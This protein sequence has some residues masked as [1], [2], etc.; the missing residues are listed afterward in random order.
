MHKAQPGFMAYFPDD[1]KKMR[2]PDRA[3]FFTILNSFMPTVLDDYINHSNRERV[4]PVAQGELSRGIEVSPDW[5]V[6]LNSKPFF[7]SKILYA[8]SNR[9]SW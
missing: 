8:N 6:K 2:L 3:Y 9:D 4:N 5:L 1:T 7:S